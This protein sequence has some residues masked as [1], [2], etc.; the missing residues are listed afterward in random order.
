VKY[1]FLGSI[2]DKKMKV[3]DRVL[4]QFCSYFRIKIGKAFFANQLIFSLDGNEM[5]NK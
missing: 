5:A 4:L 2:T 1:S 3:Y